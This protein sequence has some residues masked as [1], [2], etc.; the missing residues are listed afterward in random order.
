MAVQQQSVLTRVETRIWLI[1]RMTTDER[2]SWVQSRLGYVTNEGKP[3]APHDA[4]HI[5]RAEV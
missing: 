4:E 1:F 3:V 5:E 2:R